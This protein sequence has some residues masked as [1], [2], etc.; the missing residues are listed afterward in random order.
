MLKWKR[1]QAGTYFAR[2]A[3]NGYVV[4]HLPADR[5]YGNSDSWLL[6]VSQNQADDSYWTCAA[7]KAAAQGYEDEGADVP[8]PWFIADGNRFAF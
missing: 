3:K 4:R 2:G 8:A 5:E 6:E 7:A 1:I